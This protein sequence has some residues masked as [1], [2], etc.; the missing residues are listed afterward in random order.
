[1]KESFEYQQEN[2]ETYESFGIEGTTFEMSYREAKRMFKEK[3]ANK[4]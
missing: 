2:A 4:K 1:M 3:T